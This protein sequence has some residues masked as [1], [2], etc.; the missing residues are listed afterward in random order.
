MAAGAQ[1][2]HAK[3]IKYACSRPET[4]RLQGKVP[5]RGFLNG[6]ARTLCT[7]ESGMSSL[8]CAALVSSDAASRWLTSING[9]D[10]RR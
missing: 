1:M 3:I 9:S 8:S 2:S 7:L 4:R 5:G 10:G 6:V